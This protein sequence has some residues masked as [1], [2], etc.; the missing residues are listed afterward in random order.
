MK[1]LIAIIFILFIAYLS[2]D[3]KR[4]AVD[5]LYSQMDTIYASEK[6]NNIE[7]ESRLITI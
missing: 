2:Q 4:R 1:K 7:I 6:K 3:H 5:T